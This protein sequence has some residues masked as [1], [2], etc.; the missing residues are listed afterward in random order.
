[1]VIE[2]ER[3]TFFR[4]SQA[5]DEGVIIIEGQ[6]TFGVSGESDDSSINPYN[7][8]GALEDEGDRVRGVQNPV[9]GALFRVETNNN[10]TL[11]HINIP[12]GHNLRVN[13]SAP[14]LLFAELSPI[15]KVQKNISWSNDLSW[16]DRYIR[17]SNGETFFVSMLK[18]N[19]QRSEL[20]LRPIVTNDNT[21]IGTAPL[22]TIAQGQGAIAAINGGWRLI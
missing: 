8:T 21:M 7:N 1:V 15:A 16:Q 14:N 6:P 11:V 2:L 4:V 9:S 12:A 22:R 10:A 17:L 18:A 20:S 3:P 13:S 19:L 5:R